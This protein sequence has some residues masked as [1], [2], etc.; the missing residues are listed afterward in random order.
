[1]DSPR[2]LAAESDIVVLMLGYPHDVDSMLF[3]ADKGICGHM[4]PG[5][6]LID[7]TTS[8]PDLAVRIA[9]ELEGK[10]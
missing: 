7:H 1:M 9:K 3:D 4:K 8:S 10:G 6:Y 5:A 2:Q